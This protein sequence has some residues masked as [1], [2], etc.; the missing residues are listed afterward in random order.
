M[1]TS[2]SAQVHHGRDANLFRLLVDRVLDYAIFLLTPDGHIA[3]WNAG[4]QRVKGYAADEIIGQSFEVFYTPHDRAAGRPFMLLEKARTE[5][6]VEDEGY[7]VRKN[8]TR[9]WA[10]VVITA[11]R[12]ESG[13]LVGF[14]K[15]TR[16]LTQRR[17]TE[18]ERARRMAAERT[19]DRFARLQHASA[20]MSAAS[21]RHEVA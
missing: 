7:R 18:Q 14:A 11:L 3:S 5:G 9:F 1:S 15:V 20:A 2:V 21:R 12:E 4:A 6:R 13:D 17:A 16:D 10:D 19:A 8:G